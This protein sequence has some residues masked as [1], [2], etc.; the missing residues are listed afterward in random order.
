LPTA[1]IGTESRSTWAARGRSPRR[2]R[3]PRN[4]RQTRPQGSTLSPTHMK[5][6]H[7]IHQE[8]NTLDHVDESTRT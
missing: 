4:D 6:T 3:T 8:T 7:H 1:S 5:R 2:D